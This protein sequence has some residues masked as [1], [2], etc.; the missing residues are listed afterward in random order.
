M[1]K[2]MKIGANGIIVFDADTIDIESVESAIFTLKGIGTITK[3]YPSKDVSFDNGKFFVGLSQEDTITISANKRVR[4]EAEAQINFKNNQVSKTSITSF[5]LESTLGTSIIAGNTPSSNVEDLDLKFVNGAIVIN[6][7]GV[8]GADGKSA[9]ELAV[10]NGFTGTVEE[11]LDSLKGEP[12]SSVDPSVITDAV[13]D[14]LDKHPVS[15]ADVPTTDIDF[16]NWEG[17]IN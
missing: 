2:E 4:A 5:V 1:M 13:N 3:N 9:Y 11:W 16:L 14:Y 12:G 15:G 17:G 7:S 10:E 6:G 8:S